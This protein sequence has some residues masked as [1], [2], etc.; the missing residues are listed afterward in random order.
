MAA[1]VKELIKQLEEIEDKNQSVIFQYY[2]A[3]DFDV[4]DEDF[5]QAADLDYHYDELWSEAY[6]SL[7]EFFTPP[8]GY[9][10]TLPEW[11]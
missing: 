10:G 6:Q 8:I 2:L 1:T 3:E 11:N 4:S 9:G 7:K 5:D